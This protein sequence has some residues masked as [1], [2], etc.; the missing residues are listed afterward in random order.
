MIWG[1]GHSIIRA[2]ASIRVPEKATVK[3]VSAR[4]RV[5]EL[6][7]AP[8]ENRVSEKT[9][10]GLTVRGVLRTV[11]IEIWV[12]GHSVAADNRVPEQNR[13]KY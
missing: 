11:L 13:G 5:P 8:A 1:T 2:P 4:K 7:W 12:L 6:E 3:L 9:R 10:I